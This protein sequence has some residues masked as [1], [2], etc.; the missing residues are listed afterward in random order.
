MIYVDI[1][2]IFIV[3]NFMMQ[4]LA[5]YADKILFGSEMESPIILLGVIVGFNKADLIKYRMAH[6]SGFHFSILEYEY[7]GNM[8]R[9]NVMRLKNDY[10]G[11]K[12]EV[13]I[14]N[15]YVVRKEYEKPY[16]FPVHIFLLCL[17]PF[18]VFYGMQYFDKDFMLTGVLAAMVMLFLYVS[19]IPIIKHIYFHREIE[20]RNKWKIGIS[21]INE[22]KISKIVAWIFIIFL[23]LFVFLMIFFHYSD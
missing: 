21:V 16:A 4:C 19:R 20:W 9:K 15:G 8:Y 23:L 6:Y 13:A 12:V 7:N 3:I 5:E 2:I 18:F 17:I 10:I 14:G 1:I 11:R 22:D